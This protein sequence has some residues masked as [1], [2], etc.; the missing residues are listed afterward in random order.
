MQI[1]N[2]ARTEHNNATVVNVVSEYYNLARSGVAP[3]AFLHC[4]G[5]RKENSCRIFFFLATLDRN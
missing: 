1:C 4:D 5:Y 2:P 3:L